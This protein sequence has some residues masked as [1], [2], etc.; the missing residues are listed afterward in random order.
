MCVRERERD[1]S[2]LQPALEIAVSQVR[3]ATTEA[4][5][6]IRHAAPHTAHRIQARHPRVQPTHVSVAGTDAV[7]CSKQPQPLVQCGERS[8]QS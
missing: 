4:H 7:A 1:H 2:I 6:H 5:A 3:D 8:G